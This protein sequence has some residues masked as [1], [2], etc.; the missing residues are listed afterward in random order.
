M[1]ELTWVDSLKKIT[2]KSKDVLVGIGDDCALVKLGK[3]KFLLKSDLFVEDVHFKIGETSYKNIAKRA[4]ARVLSDFAACG[5]KPRFIGVS[6]AIP[7]HIKPDKLNQILYG[8]LEMGKKYGFSLVG[9]DTGRADKLTLDIWG[10]GVC[11]RFITRSGAKTGDYIFISGKLG[12]LSFNKP[13]I[14]RL[15]EARYLSR[16]V[17]VNAM[18]DITDGFVLDLHRILKESKKGALLEKSS[19]PVT[20]G[21]TDYYRGED[22]ELLFTVDKS[23]P[24]LNILK[25]RFFMVGR[26]TDRKYGYM[27]TDQGKN[28]IVTIK[29]YTHF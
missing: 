15:A 4:V 23:E 18:I 28:K 26:V 1:N 14:P 11:D 19:I 24:K 7:K 9:G 13:F 2:G 10:V 22:Y 17:K 20:N 27:I 8:V 3:E 16:K 12:A 21:D 6:A 25:K 5:G 29:G